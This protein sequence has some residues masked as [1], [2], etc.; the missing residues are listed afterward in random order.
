MTEPGAPEAGEDADAAAAPQRGPR[1]TRRQL[2]GSIGV[3][4]AGAAVGGIAFE[5]GQERSADAERGDPSAPEASASQVVPFH[6]EHQAGIVTPAQDR[7]H[8]A[9]FDVVTG[10][11]PELIAMLGAW[12]RAIERMTA[13]VPVGAVI[14]DPDLPPVDT[15]EALGLTAAHLTVTVGFGPTLFELDGRDRFG[16]RARRPGALIDLPAFPGDELDPARSGG[17]ILVQ[18][19]ADDPQVAFH[20]IRNLTRI[21][22]GVV[23]VRWSQ[24]GFG[25]TSGTSRSQATPRNLMGFKDGTNNLKD[26]DAALL[27][28]FVWVG[29]GRRRPRGC[30]AVPTSWR[31]GSGCA[32]RSGTVRPSPIRRGRSAGRRRAARRSAARTSSTPCR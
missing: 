26:D 5:V 28:D 15:G 11:A 18:A 13:G 31:A 25:R 32:S 8:A 24:L 7:M 23:A 19:C 12:T 6:G 14:G 29:R 3:V 21:G 17:D 1:I 10:S 9:A 16:I 4:A 20:A 22:R 2:L 27:R 30:S